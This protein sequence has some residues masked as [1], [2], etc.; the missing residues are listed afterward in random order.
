MTPERIEILGVPVDAVDMAGAVATVDSWMTGDHARCVLA[1]NPEKVITARHDPQLRGMLAS[2][3]LLIPDGIGVVMA[4][5]LLGL[6]RFTR[7][8]GAELMPQLCAL[9]ARNGYRVFL[10]GAAEDVNRRACEVLTERYPGLQIAG[11]RNGYATPDEMEAL[12]D[13]INA[14]GALLLFV[15]LGSPR[16]ELW[17]QTHLDRLEVKAIQ[18]VG[19]TFDVLAGNVRRAPAVFR[20]L[21]VEWLY[22]LLSN[23]R[24]LL[25]QT[26]LPKFAALVLARLFKR[27]ASG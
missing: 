12:V 14:S 27:Q 3:G 15:A 22:R 26:A 5:R 8:P 1:V 19:G 10:Y 24:R 4:A 9:A 11:R 23:P 17:M 16:Q 21:H 20:R 6:G 25:R 7:V 13:E 18:G 2:A